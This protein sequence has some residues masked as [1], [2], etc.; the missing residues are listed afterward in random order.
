MPIGH[1][2]GRAPK[3]IDPGLNLSAM[4]GLNLVSPQAD[5]TLEDGE[6]YT[7]AGIGL[8]I[9][10]I[11]GHSSGHVVYL[12]KDCDP[13]IVFVGDVIFAGSIGRTDFPDGDFNQLADGIR[14][15]L[16][17]L[18]DSTI[19]L[20]GHGPTTTVGREKRGNPF[21]R[22]QYPQPCANESV[23]RTLLWG[24][25]LYFGAITLLASTLRRPPAPRTACDNRG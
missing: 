11:P 17:A 7:A 6:F 8:Q 4:F 25:A 16:Y 19:L 5:V 22:Q 13:V 10:A 15:I 23:D 14:K 24:T 3:L 20:P 9:R 1:R 21:V 12:I 2:R 18:P